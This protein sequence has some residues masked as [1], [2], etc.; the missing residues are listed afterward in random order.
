[1]NR[2]AAFVPTLHV[3]PHAFK[4]EKQN[5]LLFPQSKAVEDMGKEKRK[6]HKFGS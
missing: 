4:F 3:N 1:M 5:H 6:S 2:N